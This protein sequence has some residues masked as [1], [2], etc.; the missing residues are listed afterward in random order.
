MN[1]LLFRQEAVE[2][3]RQ[4]LLGEVHIARPK[5]QRI[6][7]LVLLIIL[8][9]FVALVA[10][11]E[12]AERQQVS[13]YLRPV[14]GFINITSL[15]SGVVTGV[16]VAEGDVVHAGHPL[17]NVSSETYLG[18]GL[19]VRAAGLAEMDR[20]A[21]DLSGQIEQLDREQQLESMRIAQRRETVESQLDSLR[22]RA[23][24]QRQQLTLTSEQ[25]EAFERLIGEGY[26]TGTE[27]RRHQIAHLASRQV[28]AE[29]GQAIEVAVDELASLSIEAEQ[30]DLARAGERAELSMRLSEIAQ[31]RAEISSQMSQDLVAPVSGRVAFL[32][33][34][35][36][37][38]ISAGQLL[39]MLLPAEAPLELELLVPTESVGRLRPGLPV[40]LRYRAFPYRRYGVQNGTLES[41]SQGVLASEEINLLTDIP[42]PVYSAI[43]S[44]DHQ[45]IE[46]RSETFPLVAG[47]L[48]DADVVID[49]YDFWRFLVESVFPST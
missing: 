10:I 12:Y 41:I 5:A 38:A 43:V 9:F 27:L 4:R 24:L 15:Q 22:S 34:S 16:A 23:T 13:G 32:R 42:G 17:I 7:F 20:Q 40:R 29:I 44:L 36:G 2:H 39:A 31:R 37:Q 48:V 6:Y 19:G 35:P 30:G 11:G 14:G 25:V 33:V 8:S 1:Q 47:M 45:S 49:R 21:Q 26:V 18:P 46:W 28:L 3:R